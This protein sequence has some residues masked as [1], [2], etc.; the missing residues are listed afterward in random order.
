MT[1]VAK[2]SSDYYLPDDQYVDK[3]SGFE[4]P[5][6]FLKILIAQLSYQDPMNPQDSD[7]FITQL[8]QM[9]MMEQMTNVSSS[10]DLVSESVDYMAY[11][12]EMSRYNEMIGKQVSITAEDEVI[13]GEVGG[14]V[15]EE[16]MPY[17]Y[18]AQDPDGPRYM[19]A[20]INSVSSKVNSNDEIL[21]YF[22]LVGQQV[23][24]RS[25]DDEVTG[26]VEKVLMKNGSVA[27]EVNGQTYA[28][29]EILEVY[30]SPE[31]IEP[32]APEETIEPDE[33]ETEAV[34]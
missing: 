2:T 24:I 6:V 25:D 15:V 3:P 13:T 30:G 16:G 29:D 5:E 12:Y 22:V 23:K 31:E 20:Q 1:E 28:V 7:T 4:D 8:T 11:S 9:A 26:T 34:V 10:M 18:L 14:V 27:I 33:P 32:D 21:A 17:F 19:L